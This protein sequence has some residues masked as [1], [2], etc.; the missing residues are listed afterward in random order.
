MDAADLDY[1]LPAAAIAQHP[2]EPCDAARLLVD[3]GPAAPPEIAPM[4]VS[5]GLPKSLVGWTAEPK[6]D[7]WR[8]RVAVADRHL[9]DQISLRIAALRDS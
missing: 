8:A 6:L 2:V 7:G 9:T 5:T 3:R 4:L 1:D